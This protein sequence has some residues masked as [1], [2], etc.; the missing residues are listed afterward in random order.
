VSLASLPRL[1]LQRQVFAHVESQLGSVVGRVLPPGSRILT[2]N[3]YAHAALQGSPYDLVPTWSPEVAFLFDP[4]IE[5]RD[6]RR[7]L[8]ERRITA[9]FL[10][11]RNSMTYCCSRSRPRAEC[12]VHG[13]CPLGRAR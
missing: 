5:P 13:L 1:A 3:C 7:M 11:P 6:A 4:G 10:G 12:G 8:L 2:D 9:V